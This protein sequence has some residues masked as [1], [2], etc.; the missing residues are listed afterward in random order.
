MSRHHRSYPRKAVSSSAASLFLGRGALCGVLWVSIACTGEIEDID[1]TSPNKVQKE[2]FEGE[3]WFNATVVDTEFIQ[4]LLFEGLMSGADRIRWDLQEE[5]L[6]AYRSYETLEGAEEGSSE[7]LDFQ[8][9]VVAMFPIESHFDVLRE[10]NAATGE[11]SNII[12]E[13]T[14]D[15]PW[16]ERDYV[17]I[18]WS[19]NLVADSYSLSGVITAISEATYYDQEHELDNPYRPE[20][21]RIGGAVLRPPR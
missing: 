16:W 4:G 11:Q 12:V 2:I 6:V 13:N 17:R 7:D 18:D 15:R 19:Q 21:F 3:W 1:R 10:Y 9:T 8:G 20:V 14:T 5:L